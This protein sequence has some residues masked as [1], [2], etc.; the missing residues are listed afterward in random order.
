MWVIRTWLSRSGSMPAARS[1]W[2][3]LPP[4][5]TRRIS[6]RPTNARDV[7]SRCAPGIAPAVPRKTK[8]TSGWTRSFQENGNQDNRQNEPLPA[9]QL[10]DPDR[11][12]HEAVG[13][14]PLDDQPPHGVEP[15]VHPE[16]A[17]RRPRDPV[18]EPAEEGGGEQENPEG[19]VEKRRVEE[20]LLGVEERAVRRGNVE[21]P[22]QRRG[23]AER[24][25][26]EEVAP[27]TDPLPQRQARGDDVEVAGQGQALPPGVAASEEQPPEESAVDGQAA[28]P[29]RDD[30]RQRAAVVVPV[31]GDVVEPRPDAPARGGQPRGLEELLRTT[32]R[33]AGVAVGQPQPHSHGRG[34]E[35]AV[36]ADGQRADLDEDGSGGG[37][38]QRD[39]P[40]RSASGSKSESDRPVLASTLRTEATSRSLLSRKS[41]WRNG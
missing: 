40:L 29:H 27:A 17:R 10:G 15:E 30:L 33:A 20:L 7:V 21:L 24:L 11:A 34:H 25:L 36:P 14:E 5:S 31:E 18:A 28:L 3:G 38:H 35:H 9:G 26:V 6:E 13:P 23:G 19:F 12:E 1:F 8:C 22:G 41:S 4:T 32:P 39:V 37:E 2:T 16:E